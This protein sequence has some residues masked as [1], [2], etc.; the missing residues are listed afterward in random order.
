MGGN[1][2]Y[3][4]VVG[5]LAVPISIVL[6]IIYFF[7]F[8]AKVVPSYWEYMTSC[9]RDSD[10]SHDMETGQVDAGVTVRAPPVSC[11]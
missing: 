4:I 2:T 9:C 5:S 11:T 3:W 7:S 1:N 8:V 10:D 6:G